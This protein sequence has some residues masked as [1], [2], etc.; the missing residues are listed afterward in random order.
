MKPKD[1]AGKNEFHNYK[2]YKYILPTFTKD[3]KL[4]Y[5]TNHILSKQ[6]VKQE[7]HLEGYNQ[8]IKKYLF[9]ASKKPF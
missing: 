1:F 8:F 3:R 4:K 2:F 7:K 9:K 5:Y 6:S